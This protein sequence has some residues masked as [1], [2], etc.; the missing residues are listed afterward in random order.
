MNI[1]M[2]TIK[3]IRVGDEAQESYIPLTF[4]T[5]RGNIESRYYPTYKSKTGVIF[6][7]D[8]Q[9]DWSS[10]AKS[11]YTNLA[12][13]LQI[14]KNISS[15]WVQYRDGK[16]IE[17]SIIDSVVGATYL[18][19]EQIEKIIVVGHS[20]GS[21][22][23]FNLASILPE[24]RLAIALTPPSEISSIIGEIPFSTR[25]RYIHGGSDTTAIP[26]IE[27]LVLNNNLHSQQIR[28]YKDTGYDLEEVAFDLF[29]TLQQWI[30]KESMYRIH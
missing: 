11:L 15:L 26:D 27:G 10:P 19:Q 2:V 14:T 12:E 5:T 4:N 28:M 16:N 13:S 17:E 25:L 18:C 7:N 6:L 3:E 23:G 30:V 20:F 8:G 1:H 9:K 22:V 29:E 24:V 21:V